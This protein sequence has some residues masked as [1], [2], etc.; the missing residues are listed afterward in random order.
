MILIDPI[1]YDDIR[2]NEIW[3]PIIIPN[4]EPGRYIISN[5][6][7]IYDM[8]NNKYLK[9]H[10]SNNGYLSASL[11]GSSYLIHRLVA[12]TFIAKRNNDQIQVNHID[13]IKT[14]N[15]ITNLE[16][17]YPKE[18]TRHAFDTGLAINNIGENS[19]LSKFTN[20]QV[21]EI[22]QYLSDGF[23]YNEILQKMNIELSDN[24]RD[25]I[26]NIYRGIAWRHISEKYK[27]P[28]IDQRFR[29]ISRNQVNEICK[30]IEIGKTNK[31]IYQDV[32]GEITDRLD[33]KHKYES[34]RMIRNKN[35]FC[36]I[37]KD[38]NF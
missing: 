16:W 38:Y 34:I 37:S 7:N 33:Y 26:G 19:H 10:Q 9:Q 14:N 22:C 29:C 18:N 31:E 27:F 21:E 12:E 4:I 25:M 13:G 1:I 28:E 2:K 36:D 30:L 35:M 5:F 23:T 15:M 8:K 24:N 3:K 11:S 6:G 20:S 17:S 32:F